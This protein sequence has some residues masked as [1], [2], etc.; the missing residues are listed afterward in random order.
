MK[1]LYA[2][3]LFFTSLGDSIGRKS[4]FHAFEILGNKKPQKF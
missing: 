4:G 3:A 2:T 1:P